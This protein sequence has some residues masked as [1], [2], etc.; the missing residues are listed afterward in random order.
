MLFIPL[1]ETEGEEEEVEEEADLFFSV[2][3]EEGLRKG[4]VSFLLVIICA[5]VVDKLEEAVDGFLEDD[6]RELG[7][8]DDDD[9]D[10]DETGEERIF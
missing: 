6:V 5:V 2:T 4:L 8:D 3:V 1:R 7:N 10:S 9:V